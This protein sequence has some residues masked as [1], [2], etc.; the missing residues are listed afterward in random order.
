[1]TSTAVKLSSAGAAAVGEARLDT[2]RRLIVDD[3]IAL[4]GSSNTMSAV[5]YLRSH[6]VGAEIIARVLLE[7]LRRRSRS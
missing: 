5:E 3:G 7:P 4:Q 2:Q 6:G 1:M